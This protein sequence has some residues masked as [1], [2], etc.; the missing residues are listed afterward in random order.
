[1]NINFRKLRGITISILIIMLFSL[2]CSVYAETNNNNNSSKD[3]SIVE[4]IDTEMNKLVDSKLTKGITASVVKDQKLVLCKGYGYADEKNDIKVDPEKST[5]KIGSVSKTFV[6][7]AAMQLVEQGK[8]DM[9]ALVTKYLGADFPKFKYPVTMENLLTHTAGF[10]D[11]YSPLEV[12]SEKE[13]MT[14]KEFVTKY[15]P[16]QV[17]K[18]GEVSAYSNYGISLAGYVIE[19]ISGMSFYDYADEKMF[20]PLEMNNTTYKSAPKGIMSKAYSPEGAEKADVLEHSYPVGSV[21]S[22]GQDMAKYIEFLLGENSQGIIKDESNQK[23]FAKNFAMDN[24]LSG[25]GYVWQ[26]HEIN[27]HTFYEHGGGTANFTSILAIYPEQNMGIFISCNQ[28]SKFELAEYVFV[29]AEMLYGKDKEKDAYTGVNSRDIGGYYVPARSSFKR[30]DKFV[31]FFLYGVPKHI[32]GNPTDGFAID[33]EKLVSVGV[34]AY[35]EKNL[36]YIKFIQK[37][38]NLYYSPKQFYTSYIRVPWY[39]GTG[40][41]LFVIL[42]FIAVSLVGFIISIILLISGIIKKKDKRLI[43]A[44]IPAIAVFILFI[45]MI[46]RFIFHIDYMNEVFGGLNCTAGL[47]RVVSFYKVGA[48]LIAISGLCGIVSTVYMW[49]KKRNVF[50][51]LFSSIWSI[52]VVLFI[53]WLVQMNLIG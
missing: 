39:E 32:T 1:M 41:Q 6:A 17:F 11:M 28:T 27:G 22:T 30:A 3:K 37:G 5:F 16:D 2:N 8:L 35:R 49:L 51:R 18:P 47:D 4:Y 21:T 12:E 42:F 29:V 24:E 40:W 43:F 50:I 14:L 31:D 10:E 33:G 7:L 48:L 23:M 52:A 36:G 38:N 34:D 45:S 44:N 13:L 25:I 15:R 53:S 46:I 26:R 19:R 20:K 9:N